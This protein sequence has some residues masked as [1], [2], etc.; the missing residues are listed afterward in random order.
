VVDV[1]KHT[2]YQKKTKFRSVATGEG[3]QS[4]EICKAISQQKLVTVFFQIND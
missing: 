4:E 1:I 3:L 2:F